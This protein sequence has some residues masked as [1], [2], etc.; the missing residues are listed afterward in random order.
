MTGNV[1]RR[2]F[3]KTAAGIGGLAMASSST[4]NAARPPKRQG[5]S[6]AGLRA[7]PMEEVRVGII[8]CG[9]RSGTHINHMVAI[10]GARITS[11]C[12]NHEPAAQNAAKSIVDGGGEEPKVYAR[13]DRDYIRMLEDG[14]VDIVY[15]LTPWEWHAEMCIESMKRGAHAFVELPAATTVEDC[16]KIVDT[17]EK[18]QK[19]CMILENVCYGREELMV[20]NM[21]RQG[22]FGTITHGEGAYIHDLRG[23]MRQIERGTGSWRVRHHE[24]T[25]GSLYPMHGLGPIAQYMNIDRGDRF[26]T[27][28]SMSSLSAGFKEYAEANFPPDHPRNQATYVCGDMNSCLIKTYKGRSI[29]VQHDVSTPR[30]YSRL[31]LI[32]GTQGIFAGFPSRVALEKWGNTHNWQDLDK[33]R[34]E[35]E[36]PLWARM[37]ED[38]AKHGGHG[39]MDFVMNW[40]V[41]HCLLNGLP[42]DIN[43]YET[44]SWSAVVELSVKSVANNSAGLE[45]PDFTRGGWRTAKPLGIIE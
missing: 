15:I 19:H 3:I 45:F 41:I 7:D 14:V 1:G 18:H 37:R 23:Q 36:H 26:T 30:P 24:T 34:E 4:L 2:S 10:E 8:G 28:T 31:N 5:E 13:G 43:T 27:L 6:V 39:G 33:C 16:W 40:R 11:V 42:L 29:L 20:L 9:S 32:Q 12:D 25:D 21:C 17:A 44:A 38:A 22:A 35:Y